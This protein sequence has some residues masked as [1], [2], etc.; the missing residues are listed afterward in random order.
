MFKILCL[1]FCAI[2]NFGVGDDLVCHSCIGILPG[3]PDCYNGVE[4]SFHNETCTPLSD[5]SVLSIRGLNLKNLKR[6]VPIDA[7]CVG[8][9]FKDSGIKAVYRGCGYVYEGLDICQFIGLT[10]DVEYCFYCKHDLCN[11]KP[12]EKQLH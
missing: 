9:V 7:M 11:G 8:V 3:L 12:I 5:T 2:L 6:S 4:S 10:L 1:V